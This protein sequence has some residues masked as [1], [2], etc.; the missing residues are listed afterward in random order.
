VLSTSGPSSA[1]TGF[2]FC[3][4]EGWRTSKSAALSFV[5]WVPP[6]LRS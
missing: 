6:S 4:V 5:S 2:E 3:G 1:V